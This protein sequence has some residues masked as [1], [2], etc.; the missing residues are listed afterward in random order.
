MRKKQKGLRVLFNASVIL[1][2]M[3]SSDGA[4]GELI[5]LVK[6]K[7]MDGVISE[8]I[9]EEAIRH[10]DKIGLSNEEMRSESKSTFEISPAP[11]EE[12]VETYKRVVIDFGDAHVLAAA[13]TEKCSVLVTLDKKHLLVLKGKVRGVQILSPGELTSRCRAHRD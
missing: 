2:G 13:V 8:L 3:K 5:G 4:S 10:A 9:L 7:K 6:S 11:G 12:I 1:A